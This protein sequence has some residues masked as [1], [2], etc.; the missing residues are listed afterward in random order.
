MFDVWFPGFV[1]TGAWFGGRIVQV[2]VA[3]P[4][5]DPSLAVTVTL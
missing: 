5:S 4:V 1:N 3:V 2:K